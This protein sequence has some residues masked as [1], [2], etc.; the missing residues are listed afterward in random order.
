MK[1]TLSLL[2][3]CFLS[4]ALLSISIGA[5]AVSEADFKSFS[6]K[7]QDDEI[8]YHVFAKDVDFSQ[9][10]PLFLFLEGSGPRP[11]FRR[12]RNSTS[13]ALFIGPPLIGDKYHYVVLSKPGIPFF[14]EGEGGP[15]PQKYHDLMSLEYRAKAASLVIDH[16]SQSGW[17]DK[18]KIVVVGHSEGARVA[19]RVGAINKN[20][21]HLGL[22]AGGGMTQMF[23]F[24]VNARKLARQ[25]AISA[26][27]AEKE[28]ASLLEQFKGIFADP[29][30]TTRFWAG[31]TY[32]RWSSFFAPALDDLLPLDIPIYVSATADDINGSIESSDLIPLEFIRR[33]KKNLTYK[34]YPRTDHSYME[35]RQNVI[36][37][38]NMISRREEAIKDFM[39]WI[40][41]GF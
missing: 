7:D 17:I 30:S 9:K 27:E 19:A 1:I 15:P 3:R 2:F 34:V 40:E 18:T 23:N 5:Q 33:G 11:I 12:A 35:R 29:K 36:G 10:K 25:G 39:S 20:V 6:I 32:L 8:N 16:L 31:H 38:V 4:T 22:F 28:I 14:V 21:T 41:K 37:N 24:V 13:N 26:E